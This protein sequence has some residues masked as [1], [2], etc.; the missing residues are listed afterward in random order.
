MEILAGIPWHLKF[1]GGF[2]GALVLVSLTFFF[3][4]AIVHWFRLTS[5]LRKV[6]RVD[7]KH[8]RAELKKAFESDRRLA[9]LW[10]EFQDSLHA[11]QEER[12]GEIVTI[13][14]RATLPAETS[15]NSQF[16]VDSRLRTEFFKHLPGVLTGIGIIGTFSG[17]IDG[18]RKFQVSENALT[19]RTSLESLMHSVGEAFIISAAAIGYWCR[20]ADDVV[21][22]DS[23]RLVV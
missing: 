18:L 3:V 13:A 21:R 4:P 17:L 2:L 19:V 7:K 1:A 15:F 14:V 6:R 20:N 23:P 9:H 8:A 16:V 11:Q 22:K 10:K 5:L 12:H